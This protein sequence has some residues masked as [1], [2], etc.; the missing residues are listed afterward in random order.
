MPVSLLELVER[1]ADLLD[2]LVGS[3]ERRSEDRDDADRVLVA[4]L[5]RLLG[6]QREAIALHR[7]E[8]HLDVP[9]VG[10]LL[11]ADLDVDAH[12]QV[13]LVGRLAL[14][15]ALVLPAA[16][17]R[18]TAEHRGFARAGGRA[19]GRLQRVGGV[20]QP[21]QDV[22]AARLDLR[23]L[24]ILVLVDHVLVEALGHQRPGLRLHPGRH[25]R[26]EVQPRVA[27]DHQLV[28]DDLVGDVGRQ[29]ARREGVTRD[30]LALEHRDWRQRQVALVDPFE[31]MRVLE[32]H[33]HAFVGGTRRQSPVAGPRQI[34]Q[35]R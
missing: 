18:Q 31:A 35:T 9:V 25:E 22:H 24:R 23:G 27:V 4:A 11:P 28:V 5:H 33:R 10:E 21:A 7:D 14:R 29:L 6:R 15:L 2:R 8:A 20:P 16:L 17:E 30:A 1:R 3:V 13:R 34:T 12:H 26:R 19:A 32:R